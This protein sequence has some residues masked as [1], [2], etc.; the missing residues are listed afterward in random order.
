MANGAAVKRYHSIDKLAPMRY[1]RGMNKPPP[2]AEEPIR[3]LCADPPWTFSDK[4][5]GTKRGAQK[6]YRVISLQEIANFQ[7][8]DLGPRAV[9]FLWRVASMQQEALDVAKAWGFT[10]KTEG[11][12]I[13][14]TAG[15]RRAFGMGHYLRAEHEAFLICTRGPRV[16]PGIRSVRS[17]FSAPIGRHSE[18]PEAFFQLVEELYPLGMGTHFE[19]FARTPRPGWIQSGDQLDAD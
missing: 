17:T 19:L 11:I 12:W 8:P 18:K 15:G 1:R 13:K 3:V 4:L 7:V 10:P 5:P 2:T 16:C 14:Q 6:H 9:L